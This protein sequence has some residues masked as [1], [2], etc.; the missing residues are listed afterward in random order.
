MRNTESIAPWAQW[1]LVLL[2]TMGL[3]EGVIT[4]LLHNPALIPGPALPMF[5][6]YHRGYDRPILQLYPPCAVHDPV[7]TYT[8]RPGE[9]RFRSR[10]FDTRLAINSRGLRA[11]EDASIARMSSFW[12]IRSPWAGASRPMRPSPA[13]L[14]I[15]PV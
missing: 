1:A 10:E 7:L 15:A 6:S 9:C 11:S 13:E 8:L 5:Q 3:L 12:V 14:P 4:L 2:I